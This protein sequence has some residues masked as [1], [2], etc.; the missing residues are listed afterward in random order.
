[1]SK[2]IRCQVNYTL[3]TAR[4]TKLREGNVFTPVCQSFCSPGGCLPL[5]RRGGSATPGADTPWQTPPAQCML[6]Y[7]PLTA[8]CMLGYTPPCPVHTGIHNP[9]LP[10]A[11]D[12][13]NKRAVRIPLECILVYVFCSRLL[14]C[15][16]LC[17]LYC[18]LM[19]VP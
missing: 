17:C 9:P 4:K 2:Q 14:L 13:V 1:M 12:T 10:S 7:T 11:W 8:Q 6:G 16:L 19:F 3:I 18:G 15:S 5:V